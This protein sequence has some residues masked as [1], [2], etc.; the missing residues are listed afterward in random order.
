MSAVQSQRRTSPTALRP[1]SATLGALSRSDASASF[2]FGPLEAMAALNG[3]TEVRIRDELTD[4][5]TLD[6]VFQPQHGVAGIPSK[7]LSDSLSIAFAS[8]LLL[9]H[10]PRSLLQLVLQTLS[11]PPLP[12]PSAR[13]GDQAPTWRRL[14]PL[15]LGPD[16]PPSATEKATLINAASLSLLDGGIAARGSVAACS[17]AILPDIPGTVLRK[18]SHLTSISESQLQDLIRQESNADQSSSHDVPT[19]G[20]WTGKYVPK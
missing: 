17:C 18:Y 13:S 6:V 15:L 8:V 11:S 12:Q 9:H 1:L 2:A 10:Y 7:S 14:P 20:P 5:A 3:P 19:A 4:R 16:T